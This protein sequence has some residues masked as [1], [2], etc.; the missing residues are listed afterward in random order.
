MYCKKCGN[1]LAENVKFCNKC[2]EAVEAADGAAV[3]NPSADEVIAEAVAPEENIKKPLMYRFNCFL[4]RLTGGSIDVKKR[5]GAPVTGEIERQ[6][7]SLAWKY[8]ILFGLTVLILLFRFLPTVNFDV[9]AKG[10]YVIDEYEN[11]S[12][13]GMGLWMA[14]V[15]EDEENSVM[16]GTVLFVLTVIFHAIPLG[17]CALLNILPLLRRRVTKRRRLVYPIMTAFFCIVSAFIWWLF[18]SY[19]VNEAAPEAD[20]TIKLTFGG[21]M[22]LL[23]LFAWL[24]LS[25]GAAAQNKRINRAIKAAARPPITPESPEASMQA[26]RE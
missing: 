13:G 25:F 23:L 5:I 2:G 21:V 6:S 14:D 8:V 22:L 19:I 16:V 15:G 7:I 17:I 18:M 24:I 11:I 9:N 20:P 3:E 12:I 10:W 26:W 4:S 1:E